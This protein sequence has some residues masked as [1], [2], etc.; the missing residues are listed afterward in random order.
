M[1]AADAGIA[2]MYDRAVS[3][4][5]GA[6]ADT[7]QHLTALLDA[8][9]TCVLG[10]CLDGYLSMLASR[11][12]TVGAASQSLELARAAARGSLT[13]REGLHLD[14]LDAWTRGDMRR[15]A[16]VWDDLLRNH[17]RDVVALKVSQF[18]LSY[19]GE[20]ARMRATVERSIGAWDAAMPGY[21]FVL[22]CH[23]YALEECGEYAMAEDLGR[24][25][26]AIN[27]ADIWAAHAV[28]HVQEMQGSLSDGIAWIAALAPEWQGCSNFAL[29]LR[30]HE[31]LYHLEL[32]S[33]DRV[34]ELYD[35]EVRATS[36]DE[37]LDITNAVSLLWR[38]EQ[39]GVG[40]GGRWTELADRVRVLGDD[41]VLVFVDAHYIMAL[42]A[43]GDSSAV[44]AFVESCERF[45]RESPGTEAAVMRE[46]GLPL[47]RA[48]L[49]HREGAYGEAFDLL[50]PIRRRIQSI[51]GSHAQ[52]DVF[53]QMLIDSAWRARR[54]EEAAALLA[55]RTARRP[56]NIWGWKH[57]AAVL[58]ASGATTARAAHQTLAQLQ[59]GAGA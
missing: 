21:G 20:S 44:R 56:R 34:L 37:Y 30:W 52:R 26:V 13:S 9:P 47:I 3:S 6:R 2:S 16:D 40:V 17:P 27:P 48:A 39:A 14:A 32:D 54:H 8:D 23:A 46:V 10:H 58:D 55:E 45:A 12:S 35:R 1:G 38:L 43:A 36:T 4:Y 53:D 19:L 22:G 18:V 57:Q 28:A 25:A 42:A 41:H 33:H 7:R 59:R 50:N 31:A 51:G 15:A 5:L 11:R 29:H 24:K 49:A